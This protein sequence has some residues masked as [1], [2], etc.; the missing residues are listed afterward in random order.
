M[1]MDILYKNGVVLD[2]TAASPLGY[3]ITLDT[4]TLN[5]AH[6][7]IQRLSRSFEGVNTGEVAATALPVAP[8]ALEHPA[9]IAQPSAAAHT[10]PSAPAIELPADIAGLRNWIRQGRISPLEALKIQDGRL[11]SGDAHIHSVARLCP[12]SPPKDADAPLAG[13]GLAHKDNIA[14]GDFAPGNGLAESQRPRATPPMVPIVA[15]LKDSGAT[16]LAT[17]MMAER[18]C[19]ATSENHH[20]APVMNPLDSSLFVG[21]SSS[22]SAAAV[23]AGLC[24]GALGTDTAGSVRI[25]AASCGLLGFK[26]S[27]G[28]LAG[29]GVSPLAPS[30]DTVG[31]LTRSAADLQ[32][33]Y[34]A[35][36]TKATAPVEAS[37][38]RIAN[39]LELGR[40][41]PAVADVL[42]GF[43][44]RA[45][46][47]QAM[48]PLSLQ[49]PREVPAYGETVF[50]YE[51][52]REHRAALAESPASMNPVARLL[53]AQG[54]MLPD[55]WHAQAVAAR[56]R[57]RSAF[58][59][60]HFGEADLLV[61]PAFSIPVP[62]RRQV[63]FES[64]GFDAATLLEVYRWM[65]TASFL[66]LP[67][68][69]L[70]VGADAQARPVSVQLLARPGAEAALLAFALRFEVET[71]GGQRL[72]GL[73]APH[74]QNVYTLD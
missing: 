34:Q 10:A 2:T 31:W 35:T 29:G 39:A 33:L 60:Q 51:A 30:L 7:T 56:P 48:R 62:E 46:G 47:L 72:S 52:G 53:C 45:G 57:L 50:Y 49:L 66:D 64:P 44:S 37:A 42:D 21:G 23:A 74:K 5:N 22:G 68:L 15:R 6:R 71:C 13:V 3:D 1:Y 25:P 43:L 54:L 9:S 70:P 17:L 61:M 65:M 20:F 67:A 36:C 28:V 38:L 58:V 16:Q 32:V 27:R 4:D 63:C 69:V 59:E 12:W 14:C 41:A 18:A 11:R 19:G 24:Y 73:S 26:P 40:M 8:A 55:A